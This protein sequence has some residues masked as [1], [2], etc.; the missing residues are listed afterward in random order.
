MSGAPTWAA[1]PPDAAALAAAGWSEAELTWEHVQV[2]AAEAL[3]E[4][5]PEE[6]ADFWQ[7]GLAL[8][9]ATFAADDPRL[10][11]SLANH[12]TGLQLAGE[13]GAAALLD[14]ALTVWDRAGPW[15]E[16]LKPE[17]RARSSLFHLRME[18]KHKGGYER[19]SRARYGKLAEEGRARIEALAAGEGEMAINLER[20]RRERPTGY[21]DARRL[22][23]AVVLIAADHG[24]LV[25]DGVNEV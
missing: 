3:A 22:L 25:E 10:A 2:A 14:E 9:R 4:G 20:W 12:A 17:R 11:A 18:T 6:A 19:H 24:T 15:L 8:A 16:A 21:D 7:T 1:D 5:K 23:A 13:G